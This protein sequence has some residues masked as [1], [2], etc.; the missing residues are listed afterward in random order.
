[1]S[2]ETGH[3]MSMGIKVNIQLYTQSITFDQAK[4]KILN[5]LIYMMGHLKK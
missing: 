3:T 2:E 1:M 4:N 5:K